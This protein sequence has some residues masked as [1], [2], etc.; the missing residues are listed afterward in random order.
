MKTNL[1]AALLCV[2]ACMTGC[3]SIVSGTNQPLALETRLNG[4]ALPNASCK[5]TNNKGIWFVTTPGSVVVH[6]SFQDLNIE[7]TKAGIQPGIAI[8]H[9]STKAMAFGNILFGGVIGAGV[10]IGTGA[11]YDYPNPI[12][13]EMAS[14]AANSSPGAKPVATVSATSPT[15]PAQVPQVA[16]VAAMAPVAAMATPASVE[17]PS[18]SALAPAPSSASREMKYQVSAERFAKSKQCSAKPQA[19]LTAASPGS[20]TYTI[21]CNNGEALIARCEYGICHAL[22]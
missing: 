8:V 15:T 4:E 17:Q 1:S 18:A 20:E 6:R 11:A 19:I 12:S 7:C 21:T 22:R 10:D 14:T 9:S 3:A 5:L 13:V 16:L 2:S